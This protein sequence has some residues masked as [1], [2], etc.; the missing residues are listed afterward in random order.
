MA[1]WFPMAPTSG[2]PTVGNATRTLDDD[3][4]MACHVHQ[5]HQAHTAVRCIE[6]ARRG[7]GDGVVI[8]VGS[9]CARLVRRSRVEHTE[10]Y[11]RDEQTKLKE[12]RDRANPLEVA[13]Y[14]HPSRS[15]RLR[16]RPGCPLELQCR[17]GCTWT[18]PSYCTREAIWTALRGTRKRKL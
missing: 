4:R 12:R 5:R 7:L 16:C 8:D 3:V 18:S 11:S 13:A 17:S 1:S 9:H 15:H 10:A 14:L 2:K 6:E